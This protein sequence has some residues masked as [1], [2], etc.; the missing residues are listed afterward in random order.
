[1]RSMCCDRANTW[2][3]FSH[4]IWSQALFDRMNV[5]HACREWYATPEAKAKEEK[6]KK[7]FESNEEFFHFKVNQKKKKK[8]SHGYRQSFSS[9]F[10]LLV[11]DKMWMTRSVVSVRRPMWAT[12]EKKCKQL[13]ITEE[14][15]NILFIYFSFF[16]STSK[17]WRFIAISFVYA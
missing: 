15:K 17:R 2:I 11:S 6:K 8:S 5:W 9:L 14:T 4:S 3:Y 12:K 7:K 13:L 16:I 10:F 1:M